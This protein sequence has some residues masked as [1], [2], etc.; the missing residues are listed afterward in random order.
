MKT[1]FFRYELVPWGPL[2]S[3]AS[4]QSRH[5]SLLKVQFI[6]GTCGYADCLPW[7]E[8]GDLPLDVQLRLWREGHFTELMKRSLH[9]AQVDA[10]ARSAGKSLWTQLEIPL[11]HAL[12]TDLR[13]LTPDGLSLLS[14]QGFTHLKVKV[15]VRPLDE[16]KWL[17][18]LDNFLKRFHL[19]V[20]LD[21]NSALSF[22]AFQLFMET[23]GPVREQID[24]IEDPTLYHPAFWAE[25]Q[26]RW[27][28][29]LAL[30]RLS[31]VPLVPGSFS[32][33]VHKP[34]IQESEWAV[35]IA[36]EL[37]V[38]LVVTSYLDHPVGQLS[39]AMAAAKIAKQKSKCL[40]VCG[41]ISQFAYQ[42]HL[43]SQQLKT[44]GPHFIPP[45]GTGFGM[46]GLLV[47]LPWKEL[48]YEDSE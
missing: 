38:S 42:P 34:A 28:V 14:E 16:A 8:L 21:F 3:I 25:A 6:D 22:E 37:S 33:L 47:D 26:V 40:E 10:R 48:S 31:G 20:R 19:K 23:L 32:V 2:G 43:F 35:R 5:G 17:L 18:E 12:I 13:Q 29:R 15:G 36:H 39:A 4:A 1:H 46:D 27:G 45:E 44:H 24:F 11:S 41:L 30:D 7:P 9:F